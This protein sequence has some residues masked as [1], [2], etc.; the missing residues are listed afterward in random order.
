[1]RSL[2]EVEFLGL[3]IDDK[4]KFD[5]HMDKLCRTARFKLPCITQNQKI[6]NT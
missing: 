6:F 5:A 3:T 4:L 1:M 2:T